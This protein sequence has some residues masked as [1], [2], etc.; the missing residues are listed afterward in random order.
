MARKAFPIE[1]R[2]RRSFFPDADSVVSSHPKRNRTAHVFHAVT[3]KLTK[4][5]TNSRHLRRYGRSDPDD[6]LVRLV[7]CKFL[8]KGFYAHEASQIIS[9]RFYKADLLKVQ[10]EC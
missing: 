9:H 3:G 1:F 4:Y 5:A 6:A 8:C 7:I 10:R 2:A